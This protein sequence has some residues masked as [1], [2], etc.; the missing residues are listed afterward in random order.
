MFTIYFYRLIVAKPPLNNPLV[1][2]ALSLAM[3]KRQIVE[4][5][6]RA[7]ENPARSFV[8]P[9]IRQYMPYEPAECGDYNPEEA[10]RLLAKA[11]YPGGKGMPKIPVL[12]NSDE[13]HKMIA[14][15]V[16]RQWKEN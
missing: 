13:S 9:V 1:R 15:L 4:G 3:N 10:R 6:T 14:E 11:G 16:Q 12:F 2:R 7:G 5:V 8:P